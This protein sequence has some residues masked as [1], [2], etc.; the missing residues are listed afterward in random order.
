MIDATKYSWINHD[1]LDVATCVTVVLDISAQE[2]LARFG[3]DTSTEIDFDTAHGE[4]V[5]VLA[6]PGGVVAFEPNGFLGSIPD[7]LERLAGGGRAASA[8]WNVNGDDSFVWTTD[9]APARSVELLHA[10]EDDDAD[11]M[12]DLGLPPVVHG[13]WPQAAGES[14]GPCAVGLAMVE[15]VTGIEIPRAALATDA[16]FYRLPQ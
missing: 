14:P 3:A 8:F 2:A 13:L 15:A 12:D 4:G 16:T 7:V 11:S 5:T 9:G 1:G 10:E 6:V